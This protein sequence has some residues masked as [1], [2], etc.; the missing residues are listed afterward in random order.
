CHTHRPV[1]LLRM[2]DNRRRRYS[3]DIN[4]C[5]QVLDKIFKNHEKEYKY[6]LIDFNDQRKVEKKMKREKCKI[7]Y[8]KA[9]MKKEG[10]RE[11][12]FIVDI[13]SHIISRKEQVSFVKQFKYL[14]KILSN[15]NAIP[16][17]KINGNDG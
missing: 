14:C 17:K 2:L 7:N 15:M 9:S 11:I 12:A 16:L 10:K 4:N 5:S 13:K 1:K 8:D 6:S 3:E